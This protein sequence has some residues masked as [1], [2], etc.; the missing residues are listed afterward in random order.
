MQNRFFIAAAL[1]EIGRLLQVKGDNPFKARAYERAAQAL[2]TLDGDFEFFVK[3]GRLTELSGIG[4]ALAAVIEELC[5]TGRTA[6][7]ERLHQEL[8]PGV[9][10][11]S[12]VPGLSLKKIIALHGALGIQSI[13]ELKAACEKGLVRNVKGFGQKSEAK[14][15][16]AIANLEKGE[17]RSLLDRALEESERLLHHL[18]AAAE[19]LA[20]D[21][22]GSLRRRKE[23]VRQLTIIA[24]S[25]APEAVVD[26]F[27]RFPAIV[28]TLER[29]GD[30]C[31]ARLANGL[32]AELNIV[33]PGA[34]VAA[35]HHLTGS[36][37]HY[38]KLEGIARSKG[39]RLAPH[40][41]QSRAREKPGAQDEAAIYRTLGMQYIP[42]ELR[43]DQGEIE[44]ALGGTLPIPVT[45]E[46]I[47]GLVHC[48][49]IY[50]D[51]KNS[52]EEMAL[53]AEAMGM[54]YLTITD[55]SPS[56]FYAGG[57][58]IE[59][60]K[61]QWDEIATVQE[62]VNVKLLR[63]TESD[64][65]E[66]GSLDY[67]DAILEQFDI[68]IASVHW[69]GKL[70]RDQMTR[71]LRRAMELPLFKVWGHPL[72]RLLMSRP[73]LECHIEEVLDTIA[74]SKAAVEINGDPRRL[75]LEPRWIRA[76]RERGI[77]FVIST[78]AHSTGAVRY[79][80]YGVAT[81]RRGWVIRSEVLN[82]LNTDDFLRAV[83]P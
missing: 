50:S 72:G 28:Q 4:S 38:A 13:L 75:D 77:K 73:P 5:R 18:R 23:T 83:R 1:R 69:R 45:V 54:R 9:L 65:L 66:D 81:A 31:T 2:E 34:Y 55:H 40:D 35:L 82:T 49:T 41:A 22:A 39:I 62:K 79:L 21:I 15:L 17:E 60:L 36:K 11:L 57:V 76:A 19:V 32:D 67:P 12:A 29:G 7:L 33:P 37:K 10:E 44:A 61:A 43:E 3:S 64:I 6:V 42:P 78:D 48:H 20:A 24:A 74:R 51:G 26:Y 68:I 25:E 27:L 46:D 52:V 59:R 58:K 53:A 16:E 70:D 80:G 71:R 56:A 14:I 63:G 30:R 8:P 47:Q